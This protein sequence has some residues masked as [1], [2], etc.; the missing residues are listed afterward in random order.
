MNPERPVILDTCVLVPI[1]LCDTLLRLAESGL[2][3]P[4]WSSETRTELEHA[5]TSKIGLTQEKSAKAGRE[6]A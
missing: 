1:S 4:R 3:L 2:Y 6:D 5:L